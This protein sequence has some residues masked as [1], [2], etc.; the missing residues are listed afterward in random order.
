VHRGYTLCDALVWSVAVHET[1]TCDV[2]CIVLRV[3]VW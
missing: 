1:C 2:M 3:V